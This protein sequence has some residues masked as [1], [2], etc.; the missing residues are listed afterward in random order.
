ME[1]GIWRMVAIRKF[2]KNEHNMKHPEIMV[3]DLF[4]LADDSGVFFE[5]Y[6]QKSVNWNGWACPYFELKV[7]QTISKI[8][9]GYYD[10]HIDSFNFPEWDDSFESILVPTRDGNKRLYPIGA[11]GWTWEA[12][13]I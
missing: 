1:Q 7:A 2:I 3:K 10:K 6:H 12:L 11:Y 4:T 9:N 8:L 5:G 13:K